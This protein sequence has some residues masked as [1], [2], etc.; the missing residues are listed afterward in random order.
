MIT[1][2]AAG[3]TSTWI[4]Y[5]NI[6]VEGSFPGNF[7]THGSILQPAPN[8]TMPSMTTDPGGVL[9]TALMQADALTYLVSHL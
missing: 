3:A 7:Y 9:G 1:P 4:Q 8:P 5:A 6:P 2:A